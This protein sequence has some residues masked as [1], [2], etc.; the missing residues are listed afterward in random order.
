MST[1]TNL[2]LI[3]RQTDSRFILTDIAHKWVENSATVA[4]IC[5][6]H[7]NFLF[8]FELLNELNGQTLNYKE[9]AAI[10]K[11]SYGLDKSSV[12]EIRKRISI[13]KSAKL[14]RNVSLDKF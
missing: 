4:L 2:G 14:I 9:L 6:M 5:C 10:G 13:F 8:V 12:E 1:L 11:V 3:H 7:R